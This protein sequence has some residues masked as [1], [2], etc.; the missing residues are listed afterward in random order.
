[1]SV[2]QSK[3]LLTVAPRV[4]SKAQDVSKSGCANRFSMTSE[5]PMS[6]FNRQP[7]RWLHIDA[8]GHVSYV[9]VC[10]VARC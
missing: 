8:D 1:M 4:I 7:R 10:L 2:N 9:T 5:D 3:E 6:A